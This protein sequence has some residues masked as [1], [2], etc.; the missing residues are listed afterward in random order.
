RRR[1]GHAERLLRRQR[2]VRRPQEQRLQGV[3]MMKIP[4]R[5]GQA[6]VELALGST[7]LVTVIAFGIYFAEVTFEGMKVEEAAN[8]A[9]F[10][11]TDYKHHVIAKL[12]YNTKLPLD[13]AVRSASA[14][15]THDY[16]DFDGRTSWGEGSNVRIQQYTGTEGVTVKCTRGG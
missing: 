2:R 16:A 6:V 3:A 12:V 9:L 5:R 10:D 13:Y 14:Q 8:S 4:N 7:V 11:T 1:P 15:T